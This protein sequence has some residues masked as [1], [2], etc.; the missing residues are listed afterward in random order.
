MSI[1]PLEKK[2]DAEVGLRGRVRYVLVYPPEKKRMYR[3]ER[4]RYLD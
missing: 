2:E 4:V 1:Y 3:D